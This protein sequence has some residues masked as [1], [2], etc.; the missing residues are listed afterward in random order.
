MYLSLVFIEF[1]VNSLVVSVNF[2]KFFGFL[3]I[4]LID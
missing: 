1:E 4:F 2:I 3:V